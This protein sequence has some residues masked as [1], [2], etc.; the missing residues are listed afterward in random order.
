MLKASSY[1]AIL[2]VG[3]GLVTA[4]GRHGDDSQDAAAE[5]A[6]EA[7]D[8]DRD[9]ATLRRAAMAEWF[10]EAHTS[11]TG[12]FSIDFRRSMMLSAE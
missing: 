3:F 7:R 2:V 5:P 6:D 1:G 10:D 9:S 8:P 11:L 12:P 4:C